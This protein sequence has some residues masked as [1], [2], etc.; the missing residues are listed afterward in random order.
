[1]KQALHVLATI[2]IFAGL[3]ALP[4]LAQGSGTTPGV[5]ADEESVGT[6]PC[7][8]PP[9]QGVGQDTT[10]TWTVGNVKKEVNVTYRGMTN[11]NVRV[12]FKYGGGESTTDN[13]H[14]HPRGGINRCGPCKVADKHGKTEKFRIKP[15][16]YSGK[17]RVERW[18]PD[19]KKW[20]ATTKKKK[21]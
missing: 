13:A 5:I 19:E 7:I 16:G 21:G 12:K 3:F 1:M 14:C 8:L 11:G 6:L 9:G 17:R 18:D 2:A 10:W 15:Q 4:I 20:K